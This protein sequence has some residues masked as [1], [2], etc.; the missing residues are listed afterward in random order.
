ML[1]R[2]KDS[3][4]DLDKITTIEKGYTNP[5]YTYLLFTNKQAIEIDIKFELFLNRLFQLGIKIQSLEG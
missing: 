5:N 1:L 3:V 2:F 4:I